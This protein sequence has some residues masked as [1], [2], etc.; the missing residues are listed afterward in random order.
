MQASMLSSSSTGSSLQSDLG[1]TGLSRL[2]SRT[3]VGKHSLMTALSSGAF[4]QE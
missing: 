3:L 2:P 4:C 1:T